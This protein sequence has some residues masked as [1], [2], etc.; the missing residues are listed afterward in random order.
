MS[1]VKKTTALPS[2]LL[3][4]GS[5]NDVMAIGAL[6]AMWWIPRLKEKSPSKTKSFKFTLKEITIV[7]FNRPNDASSNIHW[8][9]HRKS[10][11]E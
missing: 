8:D 5:F 3:D 11:G 7:S 10:Q 6:D 2:D 4:A 9:R 1:L